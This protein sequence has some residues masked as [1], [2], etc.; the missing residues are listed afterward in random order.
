MFG[1]SNILRSRRSEAV[2]N[3]VLTLAWSGILLAFLLPASPSFSQDLELL[4]VQKFLAE[5]GYNPGPADG[6]YGNRTKNALQTY[7]QASGLPETGMLDAATLEMIE[8]LRSQTDTE[9]KT[10]PEESERPAIKRLEAPATTEVLRVVAVPLPVLPRDKP[11]SM[12]TDPSSIS[13]ISS[14]PSVSELSR[15]VI[16]NGSDHSMSVLQNEPLKS[17]VEKSLDRSIENPMERAGSP[18]IAKEQAVPASSND[19]TIAIIAIAI[20]LAIIGFFIFV[21]RWIFLK[22]VRMSGAIFG[23]RKDEDR[24]PNA[25]SPFSSN[26]NNIAPVEAVDDA[27]ASV[28]W[29]QR[30]KNV[31]YYALSN[32]REL[33]SIIETVETEIERQVK[34]IQSNPLPP[35]QEK[36]A[37]KE[38][39]L[40][41]ETLNKAMNQPDVSALQPSQQ[42]Q[43]NRAQTEH[44]QIMQRI[45]ERDEKARESRIKWRM[46]KELAQ[47]FVEQA[48]AKRDASLAAS[49]RR[50]WISAG[51]SIIVAGRDIGGLVYIGSAPSTGRYGQKRKC[52]IDPS[53]SVAKQGDDK[54]GN[55]MPYWPSYSGIPANA[56]A[57]YLD[58]LA[59]GRSDS[60][61]DPG[62]MFLYFY[63][64]EQHF[65]EKAADEADRQAIVHEVERLKEL[66]Q[67]NNSVQRYLGA[68]LNLAQIIQDSALP[69]I[70]E[71]LGWSNELPLPVKLYLGRKL[72]AEQALNA[73]DGL[74]W[75]MHHPDRRMRIPAQRCKAEFELL[76]RSRFNAHYPDGMTVRKPRKA[77][78]IE[79]QSASGDFTADVTPLIE[80]AL[81]ISGLSKPVEDLQ[82]LADEAMASLDKFSRY[83]GPDENGRGTVQAHSLLPPELQPLFP[84]EELD[85]LSNWAEPI[86]EQNGQVPVL[87]LLEK[88]DGRKPEKLGKRQLVNAAD[89]LAMIGIGMAPDPRFA[90]RG[91][92]LDDPVILFHLPDRARAL[93]ET[94]PA[95]QASLLEIAIGTFIA[96][97][98]GEVSKAE[99]DA[100]KRTIHQADHLS[101][102][103]RLRLAANLAWFFAVPLDL[104]QLRSRLKKLDLDQ[105]YAIADIVIKLAG[106]DGII[107][108]EE[109]GQIEKIYKILDMSTEGLYSRLNSQA[110]TDIEGDEPISVRSASPVSDGVAI[111]PE[112]EGAMLV[113]LNALD[114]SRLADIRTNT[115][116]V[117]QLLGAIFDGDDADDDV[118]EAETVE[119]ASHTFPG[120]DAKHSGFVSEL[121][122]RESWARLEF[123]QLAKEFGL[124]MEGCLEVINEWSFEHHDEMLIEEDDLFEINSDIAASLTAQ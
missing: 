31:A 89:A 117:S 121:V 42:L 79:Y 93:D 68:F 62:Y 12:E 51:E 99:S 46:R 11:N 47:E 92:K 90:L 41:S 25:D 26:L 64:L 95:Y 33:D 94:T 16:E 123:E 38:G 83:L 27:S 49:N 22:I 15:P 100:L 78:K 82:L 34:E 109:V 101:P 108:R 6:L 65:F 14:P 53:L 74:L 97:A 107:Q 110:M 96:Q 122:K 8:R 85:G 88:L 111:P 80:D 119:H 10:G 37:I 105:K 45:K 40:S 59:S 32:N 76:F 61:Y 113:H 55:C 18:S 116:Q 56:R 52:Y 54:E 84:C 24:K 21:V 43:G 2:R 36:S 67:D 48:K 20:L 120:L 35:I 13:G 87:E 4:Q 72:K 102:V 44:E 63:G 29:G 77:L 73:E 19:N 104:Q 69:L 112:T 28:F 23:K 50:G 5:Q 98:D 114:Q 3:P 17:N 66:Y 115:A 103:E 81:D 86:L 75:L 124:M 7:Q 58:W 30:E 57:T 106:A 91:P 71:R 70:P 1:G 118:S 60:S 9:E 39:A